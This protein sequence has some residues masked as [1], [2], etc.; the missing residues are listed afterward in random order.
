MFDQSAQMRL[1]LTF[2][3]EDSP[4]NRPVSPAGDGASRTS[5]GSG[6]S[7]RGSSASAS[8][9]SS[10]PRTCLGCERWDCVT[11]WETLPLSGS[12]SSGRVSAHQ[13]SALRISDDASGSL[14]PTPAACSYGSNRG[15]SQGRS[16]GAERP[17][18]EALLTRATMPTPLA[19]DHR[20][21]GHTERHQKLDGVFRVA[22]LPTPMA[23]DG[24]RGAACRQ[25][26]LDAVVSASTLPT[27]TLCGDWNRRGASPSSG[28]GL[29][30]WAGTSL[31]WREWMMGCPFGWARLEKRTA[32]RSS[33]SGRKR[34]GAP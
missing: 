7:S 12:M 14:L 8:R 16:S 34:S 11:C 33:S 26:T 23:R 17:S 20:S 21:P 27:P 18:L 19:S 29:S 24:G 9:R 22:L 13:I 1:A 30:V 28:D 10:S 15:G 2:S 25:L 3:A 5:G 4:A 31:T 6:P 32:T